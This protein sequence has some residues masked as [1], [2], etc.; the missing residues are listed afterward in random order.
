MKFVK[1]AMVIK[2]STIMMKK[3]NQDH[4]SLSAYACVCGGCSCPCST[5]N[6]SC[7]CPGAPTHQ[8][9]VV[10]TTP[11]S[12]AYD[13]NVSSSSKSASGGGYS[14]IER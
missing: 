5:C 4:N 14:N 10:Y 7:S 12:S 11:G 9:G 1:M 8:I 3:R 2:R 6:C 13:G